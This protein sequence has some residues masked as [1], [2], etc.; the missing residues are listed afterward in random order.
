[1]RPKTGLE[2]WVGAAIMPAME[3]PQ[4][5]ALDKLWREYSLVFREFDDLT[6]ARWMSQ[7][8]SQLQG[9]VWRASHPLVNAYRVGGMVAHDRQIWHKRLAAKPDGYPDAPCCRAPLVPLFSRDVREDGL[10][11]L[12]CGATV[13]PFNELPGGPRQSMEEW[14]GQYAA[15]HHVAHW[16]EGQRRRVADYEL[17]MDEAATRAEALLLQAS[18]ELLPALLDDYPV[19]IWEDHDEC[20]DVR[21][22]DIQLP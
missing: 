8:L 9:R 6:L 17:E 20:L 13:V 4:D 5:G 2:F 18:R 1:L 11:C 14:A 19:I 22:E 3:S 7:T 12:H 15:I 21:P 16:E 10:V